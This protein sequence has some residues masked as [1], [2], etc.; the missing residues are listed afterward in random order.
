MI[1]TLLF[2]NNCKALPIIISSWIDKTP[3]QSQYIDVEVAPNTSVE[4]KSSNGDWMI[5]SL[6]TNEKLALWKSQRLPIQSIMAEYSI[7]PY[8]KGKYISNDFKHLF[9]LVHEDGVLTWSYK[10]EV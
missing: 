9:D 6:F 7:Y 8:A 5:G 1:Q 3:G 2:K 10:H 4:V